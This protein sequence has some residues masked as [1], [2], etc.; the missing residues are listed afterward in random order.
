MCVQGKF[1]GVVYIAVKTYPL[2]RIRT[3]R[4][5]NISIQQQLNPLYKIHHNDPNPR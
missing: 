5:E 1:T 2:Q 4:V 3:K